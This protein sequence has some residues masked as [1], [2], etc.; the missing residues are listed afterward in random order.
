VGSADGKKFRLFVQGLT[1]ARLIRLA[2]EALSNFSDRY[3]LVQP[4]EQDDRTSPLSIYV[5][6]SELFGERRAASNLSGGETFLVSLALALGL[7]KLSS[8]N[9]TIES[10]FLDE[11]FGTLDEASLE[12]ALGA[13]DKMTVGNRLVGVIS[14]VGRIEERIPTQI[15]VH[16]ESAGASTLSGPGVQSI[17]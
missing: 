9:V 15:E 12:N 5:Q 3:T 7:S 10:L 6:D 17:T 2:N 11:G 4:D 16:K 1:M 8:T 13:L 14:H